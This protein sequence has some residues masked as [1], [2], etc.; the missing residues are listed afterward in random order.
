[1]GW[2]T[3]DRRRPHTSRTLEWGDIE[4]AVGGLGE[5]GGGD[6]LVHVKAWKGADCG[7]GRSRGECSGS[8]Y[9]MSLALPTSVYICAIDPR[10]Q[11]SPT[12]FIEDNK[13]QV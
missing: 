5:A 11:L 10:D 4:G 6:R 9:S 12:D 3:R 8:R 7:E 1:M 13:E 2:N